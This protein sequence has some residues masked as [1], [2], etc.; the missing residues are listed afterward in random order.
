MES[1][2]DILALHFCIW[3]NSYTGLLIIN[4]K[5]A[6][7]FR[8]LKNLTPEPKSRQQINCGDGKPVLLLLKLDNFTEKYECCNLFFIMV[9]RGRNTVLAFIKGLFIEMAVHRRF[10]IGMI[11]LF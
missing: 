8:I 2:V 4:A 5:G 9:F 1:Q 6:L 3:K 11:F 10:T 7:Q